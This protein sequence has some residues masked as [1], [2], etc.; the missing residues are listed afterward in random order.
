MSDVSNNTPELS[1][2][3]R[4]T[5][6]A[7]RAA[8]ASLPDSLRRQNDAQ[9]QQTIRE[10]ICKRHARIVAAY[11][12]MKNEPGGH[13]LIATLTQ[14]DL[15]VILPRVATDPEAQRAG[16]TGT[17]AQRLEWILHDGK[18]RTS[19]LGI[20]EPVGDAYFNS[21]ES[22]DVVIIPALAIDHNGKRLG[23]GGGF[24]DRALA[25]LTSDTEVWAVVDH[26]EFI[27]EVPADELDLRV[28]SVVTERGLT[29]IR[30]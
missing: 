21:L 13:T 4:H 2:Q 29:K 22:A 11:F 24:Y 15:Q 17:L 9:I 30:R 10:E 7:I 16:K 26:R 25:H 27:P 20:E 5:R 6:A 19:S 1:A 14:L 3:K 12:P 8:R 28:T 18:T 23:Q